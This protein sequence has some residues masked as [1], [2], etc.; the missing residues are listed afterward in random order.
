[1]KTKNNKK[2]KYTLRIFLF[3]L[4]IPILIVSIL[5]PILPIILNYPPDSIDN[6]FQL[7][8]DK[9]TYSQ[10][11][12][13][14]ICLI[15]SLSLIMLV[16]KL[17]QV[18]NYINLLYNA[19]LKDSDKKVYLKKITKICLN[20]PFLLYYTEI[21][22]PLVLLPISFILIQ[23]FPLTILKICL[24]YIMFFTLGA[25]LSF[26]FSQ[27]EFKHIL[28]QLHNDFPKL[29]EEIS[30]TK[31]DKILGKKLSTKLV[32]QLLPLVI[33]SL[34]FTT[35]VSYIKSC[36]EIGDLLNDQYSYL[37]NTN[38]NKNTIYTENE[39]KEILFNIPISSSH[40]TSYF[41]IHTDGSYITSD[42]SELSEFFIRYTLDKSESNDYRT[43]DYYCVDK[44]GSVLKLKLDRGEF[45][46][47]GISYETSQP[48]LLI[49]VFI[50]SFVL[51]LIIFSTLLYVTYSLVSDIKIVT[52][53]LNKISSRNNM[54]LNSH[55]SITSADE[56]KDLSMAF[57]KIQD[58]TV[59]NIQK[60]HDNQETLMESERLASLGQLIG[61]I[62]HNLKTPI[63]SISGAAEGLNDLINEYDSSI[64]DPTVNSQDHHDIAKDMS[65]W[66]IKIKNYTEYMSDI[67]TA[68]KG[69]AVTLS[70]TEDVSFDLD[71]LVK[72]V[73]ILM[74][75]ELKSSVIY[76]NIQMNTDSK[77]TINGDVNSLVQVINNMISNAI[78]AYNGKQEQN[79]DLIL[80]KKDNNLVISVR[81]YGSGLPEK[82]KDKLFK[83]MI[84]TKGKN[85]T[86]LGLYMSYSTI[87]AHFNGN[88]T[89]E[90]E[91]GKGTT[92]NIILPL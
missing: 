72:R 38:F 64:D 46:F 20:T 75:H 2:T 88:I 53:S 56:F 9:A 61:G 25:V 71:E 15:L 85:G 50:G 34:C 62:A 12:I 22:V 43:Y 14:L 24:I 6:E 70:E 19:D 52:K 92:F 65:E 30:Y 13:I 41:I 4:L 28:E 21:L 77:T 17:K 57:N 29:V 54:D 26:V 35:L 18:N 44:E 16:I 89:F 23:A 79:I 59:Q 1:M 84:T 91:T 5:Y 40:N 3:Y 47:V 55:L 39:V 87:K 36:D 11:Y 66:V 45:L 68:V 32:L 76:L 78:Q 58:L 8:I 42:N 37:L 10:Q 86:G 48:V 67:I 90:S 80:E 81:D 63:M 31:K 83:E 74:K 33:V 82:V 60:I 73:N 7:S 27:K 51:L 49:L 69:Q